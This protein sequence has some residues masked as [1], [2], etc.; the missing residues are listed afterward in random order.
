MVDTSHGQ[1]FVRISGSAHAPPLV[2][3]PGTSGSSL[4]W[5]PNI[6]ALSARYRTYALDNIWD[7]GLSVYTRPIQGRDDFVRWLDEV[8]DALGLGGGIH[9]VG[10]SYGGWLTAEYALHCPDR[11]AKIVLLAPA[12]TVQPLSLMFW[13]RT[14]LTL[15]PHPYFTHS[16][17]RWLFADQAQKDKALVD[18]LSDVIILASRSFKP[19]QPVASAVLSDDALRSLQ[20]TALYVVGENEKL[21]SARKA[22]QRLN[23]VAPQI[24]TEIIPHAGHDLTVVQAELINQQILDFL[25]QP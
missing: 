16:L 6:E 14:L 13:I 7:I 24:R 17:I 18:H 8:F 5:I 23:R 2:L 3:L 11:L 22:V 12:A 25:G 9:L 21:C 20:V 10:M 19:K 4:M 15:L 1:T